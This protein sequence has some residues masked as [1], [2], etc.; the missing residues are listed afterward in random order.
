MLPNGSLGIVR[1]NCLARQGGLFFACMVWAKRIAGTIASGFRS[2]SGQG[3]CSLDQG[4]AA[5]GFR[6]VDNMK[7]VFEILD[8]W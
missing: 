7:V 8:G 5:R 1:S 2:I 4:S 3:G 6:S